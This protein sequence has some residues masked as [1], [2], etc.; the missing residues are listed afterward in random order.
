MKTLMLKKTSKKNRKG[1]SLVE[2]IVVLVIMAILTAA[3]VPSLIGYIRQARQSTAKDECASVVQAAQTVVSS[4]YASGSKTYTNN[5]DSTK[6][7]VF[8]AFTGDVTTVDNFKDVVMSLAEVS[9]EIGSIGLGDSTS[10]G[11]VTDVTYTASNGQTVV[12]D[13]DSTGDLYTV[14]G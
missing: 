6:N 8:T 10:E 12:Y 4:A 11:V 9:G 7:V 2:L 3:L 13:A 5:S 14:S 1:F